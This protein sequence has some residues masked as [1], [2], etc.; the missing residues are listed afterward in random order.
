V[1]VASLDKEFASRYTEGRELVEVECKATTLDAFLAEQK[2]GVDEVVICKIDVEGAEPLILEGARETIKNHNIV[3]LIEALD[4]PAFATIKT[5]FPS[6]YVC[7]GI[8]SRH[9]QIFKTE[10]SSDRANN[11]VFVK[12]ESAEQI[13]KMVL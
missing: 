9:N 7:F 3:F 4:T 2:V 1:D 8:D 5:F 11:Y 10:V 6:E 13:E 12:K